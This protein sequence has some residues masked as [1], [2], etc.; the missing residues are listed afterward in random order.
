VFAKAT[1]CA[2][3]TTDVTKRLSATF[4][5]VPPVPKITSARILIATRET[6]PAPIPRVHRRVVISL[7]LAGG[8]SCTTAPMDG[9]RT[10]WQLSSYELVNDAN[11]GPL[12]KDHPGSVLEGASA[13]VSYLVGGCSTTSGDPCGTGEVTTI[14]VRGI[15]MIVNPVTAEGNGSAAAAGTWTA[16]VGTLATAAVADDTAFVRATQANCLFPFSSSVANC[17]EAPGVTSGIRVNNLRFPAGTSG[18]PSTLRVLLKYNPFNPNFLNWASDPIDTT[19]TTLKVHLLDGVR[20]C[21]ATSAGFSHSGQEAQYDLLAAGT[22]RGVITDISDLNGAYIEV[23]YTT[24]CSR[25]ANNNPSQLDANGRCYFSVPLPQVQ[26]VALVATTT[27]V[28]DP[29]PSLVTVS[30]GVGGTDFHVFGATVLPTTP[31]EIR[32]N[33]TADATH[34]LFYGSLVVKSLSSSMAGGASMGVVCCQPPPTGSSRIEASVGGRVRAVA[35]ITVGDAGTGPG[36]TGHSVAVEDW[37]LCIT[38]SCDTTPAAPS[39]PG[40]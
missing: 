37:Q 21:T 5:N 3:C 15:R 36:G 14:S 12:L 25:D 7:S 22:C 2:G 35:T 33:G 8:A 4:V 32:W 30:N 1:F 24:G 28:G 26:Y 17:V 10:N 27:S 40:P 38:G 13:T 29:P 23:L 18:A 31:L 39:P 6:P 34:P 11:C 20:T 19:Q 16:P 9:G